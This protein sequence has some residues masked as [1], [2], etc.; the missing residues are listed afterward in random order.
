VDLRP[1]CPPVYDQ[2]HL[3]SCTANAIAGAVQFDRLKAGQK[4][5]F[6]PSRLFVYYNE[7]ALHH[8]VGSDSGA[9]VR[10]GVK[11]VHNLGVCPETE[12][13]YSDVGAPANEGGPFDPGAPAAQQPPQSAYQDATRYELVTYQRIQQTLSQLRGCLAEGYPFAFGFTVYQNFFDANGVP[14]TTTPM[15]S[16]GAVG[17]HAVVGVGYND[18]TSLFTIR[19]SWGSAVLDAGYFYMP[20][21]YV[22]ESTLASDFWTLRGMSS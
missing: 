18:S 4:P 3:G 7:R 19:N 13:P 16:G 22:T 10:D 6:V 21:A 1:Q 5:D 20:Y 15:P 2:G 12:W 14:L 9:N 17:G 11:T 8:S